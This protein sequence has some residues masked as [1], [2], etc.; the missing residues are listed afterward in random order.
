MGMG[1]RGRCKQ[2]GHVAEFHDGGGFFF[3]LLHCDT[4][5]ADKRVGFDELGEMHLRYLKGLSGPYAI[6]SMEHD[7]WVRKNYPGEPLSREEYHAEVGKLAGQCECGG[8]F[9]MNAPNRC[10]KCRST[11][12]EDTGE[13]TMMYD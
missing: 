9:S 4:C 13:F 10:P 5:G 6:I 12:I 3:H 11:D 8:Q 7:E 2:C 1:F